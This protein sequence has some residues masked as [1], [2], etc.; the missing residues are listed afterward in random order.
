MKKLI[1]GLALFGLVLNLWPAEAATSS[2]TYPQL[3]ISGFKKWEYKKVDVTP[4]NNYFTGLTHL[5]GFYPTYTGGPW[6]ERLQLKILGKLSKN[7]SISYDLQQQP[8]TPDKYDVKVKYYNNELT[9]GDFSANFSG[10]EFASASKYL[11]GVMLTAKGNWYDVIAIPSAKLKSQ[12]QSLKSQKGNNTKGPYSLGHG[13]IV[14]GS[15]RI[16]LNGI[17]LHKQVDYTIDYF[18]GK[19]TFNQILTQNDEFKYTYEYTNILDLFFPSLS[20]RDFF[21][22]QSRFTIDPES[23]GKPQPKK[24]PVLKSTSQT[25]PS[26]GSVEAMVVEEEASGRY[27]LKDKPVTMFSEHL[28]FMGVRLEKNV[29]YI[30]RYDEGQIKLLTR[31]LPTSSEALTISYQYY[32]TSS[33]VET[34]A[35]TGSRGPYKLKNTKLVAESETITLDGKKLIRKLDY[36]ID[37]EKSEIIFG[38]NI[39]ST[40]QINVAY[41]YTVIA[42]PKTTKSKFPTQ[43]KV[44]TTYLKESAKQGASTAY[45]TVI[46]TLTGQTAINNNYHVYLQNRPMLTTAETG[47]IL[48]VRLNGQILTKEVDYVVPLTTLDSSTGNIIVTPEATLGY[49]TDRTDDTDGYRTGT[50]RLL[51]TSSIATTSEISVTYSYGKSIVGNYSGRGDGTRGPYYLRNIRNVVP[52][53][54]TLQVW[55]QGSSVIS[56][57]TRNSSFE[58]DAGDKG[59]S[60]NYTANIPS[61]TFNNELETT[62]SFK[63]IYQYIPPTG[64]TGGDIA[65]SVFGVD[66]SFKIGEVFAVD[67]AFARSE[68]DQLVISVSTEE[69]FSGNNTKQY[70][71]HSPKIIIENSEKVTINDQTVNKDIDYYVSYTTPGLINFYYITPSSSDAIVVEYEY[72]EPHSGIAQGVQVK[73]DQAVKLG[74]ETKLFKETLTVGGTTKKIGF[75]FTPM[76][77]TRIGSGS[78]YKEYH[79]NYKPKDFHSFYTNYSYKQNNNPVG[80]SRERFLR[81]YDNSIAVGI[82]PNKKAQL[83]FN[84]RKYITMDDLTQTVTAH[85]SDTIQD[86]YSVS[87]VPDKWS[88]GSAVFSQKYDL[89]RSYRQAD[90]Q[91][92]SRNASE[93]T[94]NYQHANGTLKLSKR[95]SLGYDYQLSEPKVKSMRTTSAEASTDSSHY[96][97]IDNSYNMSIDLTPKWLKKLTTRISLLDRKKFTYV[98]NFAA[99]D[100]TLATRNETFRTDFIPI[101]M[102]TS[103]L[104]H[105][106]QESTTLVVGGTNPK[107]ESTSANMQ[108]KPVSWFSVGWSGSQSEAIPQTGLTKR[109]SGQ[110]NTYTINYI[111]ISYTALKLTSQFTL[112]DNRQIAPSGTTPEVTTNTNSFAQNYSLNL[113]PITIAPIKLGL[114]IE[115]YNNINDHPLIASQ[116]DTQTQNQTLTAGLKV[117]PTTTVVFDSSYNLKVTKVIRDLKVAS[118]DRTKIILDNII[119]YKGFKWTTLTYNRKDEKNGGEIQAGSVAALNLEKTTQTLSCSVK[120]PVNNPVLRDFVFMASLKNVGYKNLNRSTD[121]FNA[122]LVTFE[123]TLNF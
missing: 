56:T 8:E 93:S 21:G 121:D 25:F 102:L 18:E 88:F 38:S 67:A 81:S 89:Q 55:N 53:T 109:T 98:Q 20:K 72:Q 30:I 108:L 117:T 16:E 119:T 111:P 44:G 28:T 71:L 99:T 82:N 123:G 58:P 51:N 120:V 61:I 31:F 33:E 116:I 105:N 47:A 74:A 76:G 100:E 27:R 78:E 106:R 62:K 122:S 50:I 92:D 77:G 26:S 112:R 34:I 57:Y 113:V 40:S 85:A 13:S 42:F 2:S 19:I 36:S 80:S 52:G 17:A 95:F 65:Q 11:N 104:S 7:L 12:T 94:T 24:Q 54:E 64:Y 45:S 46:E 48:I 35:G 29:D 86:S 110:G 68:T 114:T 97:S 101:T 60:I 69:S 10:N 73:A 6:Q 39:S 118:Q 22:F 84:Y 5:G 4:R 1:F 91:S 87:L 23:F 9:F 41:R 75:D 43:L 59:Y 15:E 49:I 115:N 96:R 63:I 37:N 107:A 14:E 32:Q 79:V 90:T 83:S 66:S 70:I 103:S 3:D